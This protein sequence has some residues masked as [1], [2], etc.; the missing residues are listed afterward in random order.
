MIGQ[1]KDA[2]WGGGVGKQ[3]AETWC[4]ALRLLILLQEDT[5]SFQDPDMWG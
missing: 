2:D 5:G 3:C 4:G 1:S